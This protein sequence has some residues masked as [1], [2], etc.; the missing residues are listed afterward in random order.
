MVTREH[1]LVNITQSLILYQR[2][3]AK[4]QNCQ[5]SF[6]ILAVTK[7][8][9]VS[10]SNRTLTSIRTFREDTKM[11]SKAN[12]LSNF[13]MRSGI[14]RGILWTR[15]GPS[16]NPRSLF[17]LIGRAGYFLNQDRV[18]GL[19]ATSGARKKPSFS[20]VRPLLFQ[21]LPL[22]TSC[23]CLRKARG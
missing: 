5:K 19:L 2:Y 18:L 9:S 16:P 12:Q 1:R 3:S 17:S 15:T 7:G 4:A 22:L 11:T 13:S 21:L 8:T 23:R 14:P 20:K 10:L 6:G